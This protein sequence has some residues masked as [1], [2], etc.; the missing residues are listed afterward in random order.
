MHKPSGQHLALASPAPQHDTPRAWLQS[1]LA[2]QGLPPEKG[3]GPN[4]AR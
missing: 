3:S 4:S 2:E 1:V